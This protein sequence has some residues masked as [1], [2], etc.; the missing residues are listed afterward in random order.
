MI[1]TFGSKLDFFRDNESRLVRFI[2]YWSPSY[3]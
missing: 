3:L 2:Y 1:K